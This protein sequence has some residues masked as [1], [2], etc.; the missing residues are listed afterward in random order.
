MFRLF[1]YDLTKTEITVTYPLIYLHGECTSKASWLSC[2]S[3]GIVR[4]WPVLNGYFKV[5]AELAVGL[6][7]VHLTNEDCVPLTIKVIYLKSENPRKVLPVYIVCKNSDGSF[8]SPDKT[9]E[10][11]VDE[12][13]KKIQLNVRLMQTFFAES[14]YEHGFSRKTFEIYETNEGVVFVDILYSDLDI[15]EAQTM[16][17]DSLYSYFIEE[18]TR[19]INKPNTKYLCFMSCTRY[20]APNEEN[21]FTIGKIMSYV[22]GHAALGGG[23]MALFGTGSFH[24]WATHMEEIYFKFSD[25]TLIDRK[26]MFDDSCGRGTHWAN[27]S[28]SLGAAIH[29]LGHCFDLAHTP[30]GIMARGHDDMNCF[31]IVVE[32]ST[33]NE[34]QSTSLSNERYLAKYNGAHWHRASAIILNY[35]KWFNSRS[36]SATDLVCDKVYFSELTP[37]LMI[38]GR[39]GPFGNNGPST[40]T[41]QIDFDSKVWLNKHNLYLKG[42]VLFWDTYLCGI[43]FIGGKLLDNNEICSQIYGSSAFCKRSTFDLALNEK[44]TSITLRSGAWVDGIQISS[45][46]KSSRW[47]GGAGG[48][49]I[50][51]KIPENR[52]VDTIFGSAGKYV[53]SFGLKLND[54]EETHAPQPFMF[55]TNNGIR[56]LEFRNKSGEIIAHKEYLNRP[57]KNLVI[58]V[59]DIIL[60]QS[61]VNNEKSSESGN[62]KIISGML[63]DDSGEVLRFHLN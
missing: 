13:L 61:R 57:P 17:P 4:K 60:Y 21:N 20:K 3:L 9:R 45:N 43:Q 6:N 46:Y 28:T 37:V 34:F 26:C 41:S 15:N 7:E 23:D 8:I 55:H 27:Y 12:A 22:T 40:Q 48:N 2:L 62:E 56:L 5:Y 32:G 31:Y 16:S 19:K 36:A 29:E 47:L 10:N 11:N 51:Y 33:V 54:Y 38:P 58:R 1:N 44:I 25:N 52:W 35:H 14:M 39:I 42:I 50:H 59:E 30:S 49:V 53:G 24:T 18:I 63:L